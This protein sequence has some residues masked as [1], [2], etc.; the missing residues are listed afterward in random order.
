MWRPDDVFTV[1]EIARA[2]GVPAS[3]VEGLVSS[4]RLSPIGGSRYFAPAEAV[5]AGRLALRDIAS[6]PAAARAPGPLFTRL[7]DTA[8]EDRGLPA[9][10]SSL[11]HVALVTA[12]VWSTT[13]TAGTA[14]TVSNPSTRL[15]FWAGQGPGGGGG[16]PG[17][18]PKPRAPRITARA[19]SMSAS[20]VAEPQ[21]IPSRTLVAPVAFTAGEA[22][23][24]AEE[25]NGIGSG[26]GPGFDE[27][28]G[29]GAGG[30]PYRP[31]SGIEPPR[32]LH[33][34]KARYTETARRRGL[35]GSVVLEIVVRDDGTVGDVAVVRGLG[36]GLDEQAASA[37][38]SWRFAPA[39]RL[40][41]PVDVI[42]E[43]EV[44]FSLR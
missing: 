38:R 21:P 18:L 44:D 37:V 42:V 17:R 31:G 19:P 16:A 13:G 22:R 41:R 32:L 4:G 7:S 28:I 5:R 12:F 20:R 14:T 15:V 6:K 40:G 30:G 34:V 10:G 29:G 26:T 3:A 35:T 36:D 43:V 9:L 23:Q 24:D 11:L 33:E 8:L 27:G 39:T 25:P 2:A 1:D